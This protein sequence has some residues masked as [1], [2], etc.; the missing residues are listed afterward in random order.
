M[1]RTS[2]ASTTQS[3]FAQ[4]QTLIVRRDKNTGTKRLSGG[5]SG[6][7]TNPASPGIPAESDN[8]NATPHIVDLQTDEM[9]AFTGFSPVSVESIVSIVSIGTYRLTSPSMTL[10]MYL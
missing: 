10:P 6:G 5:V 7:E 8:D 2:E 1:K 4:R 9:L 3:R